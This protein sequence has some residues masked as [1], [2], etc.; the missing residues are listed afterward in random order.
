MSG[1]VWEWT[2][3]PLVAYAG[4]AAL[5]DSLSEYRVIRGGAFDTSDEVASAWWRGYQKANTPAS[6]LANTG[7]RCAMSPT[8]GR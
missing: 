6:K 5:D 1:N 4:G 3:S 8:R 7:F 2:S